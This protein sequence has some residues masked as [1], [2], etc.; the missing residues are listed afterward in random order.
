MD[1]K[2]RLL[3]WEQSNNSTFIIGLSIKIGNASA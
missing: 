3:A 2:I 1:K